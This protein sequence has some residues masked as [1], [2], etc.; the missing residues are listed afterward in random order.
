M[1]SWH[2]DLTD[3][4]EDQV[5]AIFDASRAE[6]KALKLELG[7]LRREI[8]DSVRANGYQEDQVRARI[9]SEAPK[10]VD[11]MMLRI[12]TMARVYEILTPEQRARI[13]AFID[14]GP[15]R[16]RGRHFGRGFD[17]F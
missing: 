17:G 15:D 6:G 3:A 16:G 5:E 13:E 2:L 8:T 7:G 4:Q 12:R 10:M 1:L 9:E 11:L 14:A